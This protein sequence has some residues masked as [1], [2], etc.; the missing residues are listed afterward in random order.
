MVD[1]IKNNKELT[2]IPILLL[3]ITIITIKVVQ[4]QKIF[5]DELGYNLIVA[6]RNTFLTSIMKVVT[7]LG[8]LPVII[9]VTLLLLI[10]LKNKIVALLP[11][12]NA[13]ILAITNKIIKTIIKRPRP[14]Y[15]LIKIGGY[16]FP[17]GH[18][19][20]SIAL[21]GTIIILTYK[22]IKDK[23]KRN[24]IISILTLI[25]ITVGISRIYLGVHYTS[26]VA[27]GY[28]VSTIYLIVY[29]NLI[30]KIKK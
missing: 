5:I 12:I 22:F 17:S 26:D 15:K 23:T 19:M 30:K 7:N 13:G 27:V 25:I 6:N 9:I 8:D 16:S 18:S 14:T 4:N 29:T 2:I 24:I 10:F 3:I 1:K 11:A 28:S 20:A 21:Y